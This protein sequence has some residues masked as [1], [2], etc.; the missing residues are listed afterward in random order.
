MRARNMQ[1]TRGRPTGAS[2]ARQRVCAEAARIMAEEGINDFQLA[3]RRATQRLNLPE[4]K[5]LPSNQEVEEALRQHLGLFHGPRLASDVARLRAAALDAM[6]FLGQHE[7]RLVGAALNG[8]VTPSS[9]VQL[10]I[11]ADTPEEVSLLFAEHRIPVDQGER[12]LRFGGD[13]ELRVPSYRFVADG[14]PIEVCVLS[15]AAAREAPLSPVDGRP[16]QRANQ[17]EV[18]SLVD[19]SRPH[20]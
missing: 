12:R 5:N 18:E 15:H 6:R 10:H 16:M 2:V 7:P 3:K 9:E 13:R 8:V 19:T 4:G 1:P 11:C 14:V 20:P 17:R